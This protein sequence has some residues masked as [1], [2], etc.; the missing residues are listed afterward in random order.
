A[1]T[2]PAMTWLGLRFLHPR[3][4]RGVDHVRHA[5]AAD[6]LDRLVDLVEAEAVRRHQLQREALRRKLRQ[7]ELAGLVAVAA[8]ALHGDE[9]H[10]ELLQ[11][12]VR[13]FAE[14]TLRDD[15]AGLALERLDAEQDRNRAGARGAV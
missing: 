7:S 3:H 9:L 8:G 2:S 5:L 12:E 4:Q 11:W 14:L 6:R 13:K 1:G 10:G 15:H